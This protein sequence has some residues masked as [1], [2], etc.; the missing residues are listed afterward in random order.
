MRV[1]EI[2]TWVDD[3]RKAF[4]SASDLDSLK[5]AIALNLDSFKSKIGSGYLQYFLCSF[6]G[7]CITDL[8]KSFSSGMY[9]LIKSP[10]L[11]KLVDWVIGLNILK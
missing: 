10:S 11:S 8:S 6:G 4:A 2:S 5:A 7:L 3:A 9:F 1:E